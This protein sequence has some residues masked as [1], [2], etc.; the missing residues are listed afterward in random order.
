MASRTTPLVISFSF[1]AT[2]V[3]SASLKG[4]LEEDRALT[5]L[6]LLGFVSLGVV[7]AL[8]LGGLD[9]RIAGG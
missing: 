7:S 8:E 6:F 4:L 1:S 3:C 9:A 2:S 5:G